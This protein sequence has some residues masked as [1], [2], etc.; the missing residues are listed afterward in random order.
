[1]RIIIDLKGKIEQ[2]EAASPPSLTEPEQVLCSDRGAHKL[3]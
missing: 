1:M 2:L 3:S